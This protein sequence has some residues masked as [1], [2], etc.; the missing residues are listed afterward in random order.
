MPL[1]PKSSFVAVLVRGSTTYLALTG[2]RTLQ[3][4]WHCHDF[5]I[6]FPSRYSMVKYLCRGFEKIN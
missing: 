1:H 5:I 2:V 3:L 6:S 4:V